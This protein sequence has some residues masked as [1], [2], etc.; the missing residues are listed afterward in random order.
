MLRAERAF[1]YDTIEECWQKVVA[2]AA[3]SKEDRA[4]VRLAAT[5]A[6]Q[7]AAQAVDLM[8]NAGGASSIYE[9]N[10]LERCFRDIHTLTQHIVV[11]PSVMET[12]GQVLFGL[13]LDTPIV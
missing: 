5:S 6:A 9:R 2:G 4:L 1:L 11:H 12:A 13:E 8:Y 10:P 7:Y 3:L